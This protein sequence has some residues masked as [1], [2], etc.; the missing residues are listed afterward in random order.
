MATLRGIAGFS[1]LI[2]Y[3]GGTMENLLSIRDHENSAE[4]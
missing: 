2:E 4:P 3:Y 1:S